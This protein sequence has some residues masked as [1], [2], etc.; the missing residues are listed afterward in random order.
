LPLYLLAGAAVLQARG[1]EARI[2][3]SEASYLPLKGAP[4]PFSGANWPESLAKL[5]HAARA[6]ASGIESGLFFQIPGRNRTHCTHCSFK[7]VCDPRVEA[8]AARKSDPRAEGFL[9]MK[10]AL[11]S[12]EEEP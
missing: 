3:G 8:I 11:G 4:R 10:E 1:R 9:R 6:V 7:T 5:Q 12:G 2:E